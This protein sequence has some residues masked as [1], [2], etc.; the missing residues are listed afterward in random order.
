[1]IFDKN[2]KIQLKNIYS[3]IILGIPNYLSIFFC[4][5]IIRGIGGIIVVF[6]VLNIG[7]VLISQ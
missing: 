2:H 6:P 1:M 3:G 7:V 4:I 5:E